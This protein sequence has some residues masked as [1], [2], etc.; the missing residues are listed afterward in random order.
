MNQHTIQNSL[1][2]K[3]KIFFRGDNSLTLNLLRKKKAIMTIFKKIFILF[4]F[5]MIT[6]SCVWGKNY[7]VNLKVLEVSQV[8][9]PQSAPYADA[10]VALKSEVITA[11]PD[12]TKN[13]KI[14]ILCQ[15]FKD[16]KLCP[17]AQFRVGDLLEATLIE[18]T[19]AAHEIQRWQQIDDIMDFELPQYYAE[20]I[21]KVKNFSRMSATLPD[22]NQKKV[23]NE[24]E[25]TD[26]RTQTE[27]SDR[28]AAIA[29]DLERVRQ[30][31]KIHGGFD[32]WY[33]ELA[34][35]HRFLKDP[36]NYDKSKTINGAFFSTPQKI[37]DVIQGLLK[38][39]VSGQVPPLAGALLLKQYLE[40]RGVD[41][42]VVNLP[43]SYEL[44]CDLF[45]PGKMPKDKISSPY[46]LQVQK[47]FL[48][49][50]IEIID[51]YPEMLRHRFDYSQIFRYNLKDRHVFWPANEILAELI[52][53]RLQRYD[54]FVKGNQADFETVEKTMRDGFDIR[55]I[56]FRGNKPNFDSKEFSDPTSLI[57][58]T[59]DSQSYDPTLTSALPAYLGKQTGLTVSV[60][61]RVMASGPSKLR[62]LIKLPPDF[63][64]GKK[65][66]ILM[67]TGDA[68]A[69]K[70]I[71]IDF[72]AIR[73]FNQGKTVMLLDGKNG[74]PRIRTEPV[75]AGVELQ[76]QVSKKG[77]AVTSRERM[78]YRHYID[79]PTPIACDAI[80]VLSVETML[81]KLAQPP[82]LIYNQS[83]L[84]FSG[85]LNGVKT[86]FYAQ[87]DG[88]ELAKKPTL[89][90]QTVTEIG[91]TGG[92]IV[93]LELRKVKK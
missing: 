61:A 1:S 84:L 2:G 66:C 55:E 9:D 48:E 24:P 46:R 14:I 32:A 57:V 65:V 88:A 93:S 19:G 13:T 54:F 41:L 42:M 45:Y 22:Q 53:Q 69:Q 39:P 15:A 23:D 8:P 56:R 27:K 85:N 82:M 5:L 87:V 78:T 76:V 35:V 43:N 74:F 34:D 77:I 40:Q 7:D 28:T 92:A 89:M 62:D 70:W 90:I 68:L 73:L 64:N 71:K 83:K 51:P 16:R 18:F 47:Q 11:Q 81:P 33:A 59:G 4:L 58:Y 67:I 63:W 21:E 3:I 36:A 72:E 60:V 80:Y 26:S 86:R 49:N 37:G 52:G 31:E 91:N 25:W 38:K 10:L 6:T 29:A 44:S 50:G 75:K 79:V 30:L 12:K 17:P 20:K